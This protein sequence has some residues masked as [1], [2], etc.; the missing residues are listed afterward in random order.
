EGLPAS[1]AAVIEAVRL[2]GALAALRGR[3]SPGL[4]EMNDASLAVM[5]G[6]DALP[7]LLI[8]ERLVIGT[9][10]GE[11]AED[12]PQ[13]PLQADLTKLLKK[14]RLPMETS[15]S[16]LSLDLRAEAGIAKSV[17]FNRLTL[18]DIPWATLLRNSGRGTFREHWKLCWDPVFGIR[19]NQAIRFG[20]TIEKAAQNAALDRIGQTQTIAEAAALIENCLLADLPQA[21]EQAI[22]RLE[23]LSVQGNEVEYL[24]DAVIPLIFIL[25]YGTARP[26]PEEALRAL[27]LSMVREALIRLPYATHNIDEQAASAMLKRLQDFH[28]ALP[29]LDDSLLEKW[30][31]VLHGL[32][33][34][35]LS[36]PGIRGQSARFLYDDSRLPNEELHKWLSEA[37]SY[38][39]PPLDGAR[40]L[41]GFLSG[42]ADVILLDATLFGLMDQWLTE[43]TEDTFIETLPLIRR[44]FSGF[45]AGQRQRLLHKIRSG[46][47]KSGPV[48]SE[49]DDERGREY[50]Q[51]AL[52]LLESI[53]GLNEHER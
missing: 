22:G 4:A 52:P 23:S 30:R 6:G 19:L 21:A 34:G 15:V 29:L 33:A 40:W 45:G 1:T 12:V 51:Q 31:N 38:G 25:R 14:Y 42:N 13:P 26:I 47:G 9:A 8:G 44:A 48:G 46:D 49:I 41:E 53:L 10:V 36:H 20:P 18:L 27:A 28:H 39:T 5:C 16:E 43:L 50:F 2:S 11:V 24:I 17:L 35:T 3:A 32:L 37:L 7:L